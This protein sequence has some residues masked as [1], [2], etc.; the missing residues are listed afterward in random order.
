MSDF[1]YQIGSF[2]G[3]KR[4]YYCEVV[5]NIDIIDNHFI[6]FFGLPKFT[7]SELE[8]D[9]LETMEL[10]TKALNSGIIFKLNLEDGSFNK[11]ILRRA[12]NNNLTSIIFIK[13]P[14]NNLE[15]KEH[16]FVNLLAKKEDSLLSNKVLIYSDNNDELIKELANFSVNLSIPPEQNLSAENDEKETPSFTNEGEIFFKGNALLNEALKLPSKETTKEL[17][18]QYF[19]YYKNYAYKFYEEFNDKK[20]MINAFD[21]FNDDEVYSYIKHCRNPEYDKS[22][23]V[24]NVP[25]EVIEALLYEGET[26]EEFKKN[27]IP[28]KVTANFLSINYHQFN[29]AKNYCMNTYDDWETYDKQTQ[30]QLISDRLEETDHNLSAKDFFYLYNNLFNKQ[31]VITKTKKTLENL[32]DNKYAVWIDEPEFHGIVALQVLED[33]TKT[34]Q[35]EIIINTAYKIKDTIQDRLDSSK[36]H[37][38]ITDDVYNKTITGVVNNNFKN[39]SYDFH[40]KLFNYY[41]A[42]YCNTVENWKYILKH[43]YSERINIKE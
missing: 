1:E 6:H 19:S 11:E 14:F 40:K 21:H 25:T 42:E 30:K 22:F 20:E 43:K 10:S 13:K 39:E 16:D 28:F 36:L 29:K 9:N 2:S 26:I 5:G 3:K 27:N 41:F 33:E 37:I 7:N 18:D 23:D 8:N 17:F 12:I 31:N 35:K 4:E 15:G 34:P 38:D 32:D 24:P